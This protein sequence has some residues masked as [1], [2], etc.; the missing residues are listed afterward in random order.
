MS[1]HTS[2]V[3]W[4]GCSACEERLEQ[5]EAERDRLRAELEER[6]EQRNFWRTRAAHHAADLEDW[7][8]QVHAI[9]RDIAQATHERDRYREALERN[10][11][12][13]KALRLNLLQD[14]EQPDAAERVKCDL[15]MV[16]KIIEGL[17][18]ALEGSED[19]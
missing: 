8:E 11:R 10:L 4:P 18:A 17:A 6:T 1:E 9:A 15:P 13:A 7:R 19:E 2:G 5:V 16:G 14:V 3:R 12:R